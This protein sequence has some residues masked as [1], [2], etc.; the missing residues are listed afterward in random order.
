MCLFFRSDQTTSSGR[1]SVNSKPL[2]ND[3]DPRRSEERYHMSEGIYE[4]R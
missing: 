4:T 2:L 1:K 3:D